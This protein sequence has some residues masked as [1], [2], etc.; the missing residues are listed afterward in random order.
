MDH[1]HGKVWEFVL[2]GSAPLEMGLGAVIGWEDSQILESYERCR[3][4]RQG[5]VVPFYVLLRWVSRAR[6]KI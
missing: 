4:L 5:R 2:A 3:W 6:W 1:L